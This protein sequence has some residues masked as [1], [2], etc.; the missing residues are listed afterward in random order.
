MPTV[1][2][3]TWLQDLIVTDN[4]SF[5]IRVNHFT[6]DDYKKA[7][8]PT[9]RMTGDFA[10]TF[11]SALGSTAF[12]VGD[13][14]YR[15]DTQSF[16]LIIGIDPIL[17]SNEI[18]E[19]VVDSTNLSDY[20]DTIVYKVQDPI[21]INVLNRL[22]LISIIAKEDKDSVRNA[23]L[24]IYN[25]FAFARTELYVPT[26]SINIYQQ[27]ENNQ[28]TSLSRDIF[29]STSNSYI[30][31]QTNIDTSLATLFMDSRAVLAQLS[32]AYPELKKGI[33]VVNVLLNSL[34]KN[35]SD[36]AS[37]IIQKVANREIYPVTEDSYLSHVMDYEVS[38]YAALGHIMGLEML[39]VEM[40][41]VT[42]TA[43]VTVFSGAYSVSHDDIIKDL[44]FHDGIITSDQ[45]SEDLSAVYTTLVSDGIFAGFSADVNIIHALRKTYTV[46]SIYESTII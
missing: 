40:L 20:Y 32:A 44:M 27:I 38:C 17:T 28:L 19:W 10:N 2:I 33:D 46:M 37:I 21:A 16:F 30:D 35:T 14:Y 4:D 25:R 1:N 11:G 39:V 18:S 23:I 45:V 15:E 13:V 8:S 34:T 9:Y 5:T 12:T 24:D 41:T 42:A 36:T 3:P 6:D 7:S 29:N 43:R 22:Y 26:T 31:N